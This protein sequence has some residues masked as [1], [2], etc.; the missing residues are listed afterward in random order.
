MINDVGNR[1]AQGGYDR[2][3]RNWRIVASAWVVVLLVVTLL[4]AV[5]AVAC[6]RGGMHRDGPLARTVIPQHDPCGGAGIPS[7]ANV[8]GC[9]SAP[10]T[11]S[12]FGYW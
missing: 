5:E 7:V 6:R 10:P 4:G 11:G 12:R 2:Q 1:P 8:D 9:E 3:F